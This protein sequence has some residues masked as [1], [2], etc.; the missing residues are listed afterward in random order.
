MAQAGGS[1]SSMTA[2]KKLTKTV[3]YFNRRYAVVIDKGGIYIL[4][5][6][7][8]GHIL[9]TKDAFLATVA[10]RLVKLPT[11]QGVMAYPA[12]TVWLADPDRRQYIGLGR[13]PNREAP[14]GFFNTWKPGQRAPKKKPERLIP[15]QLEKALERHGLYQGRMRKARKAKTRI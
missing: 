10:D 15:I 6:T 1:R 4:K 12:A 13:Y 11:Q 5:E 7:A 9:L 2:S 3:Q 8:G 14:E